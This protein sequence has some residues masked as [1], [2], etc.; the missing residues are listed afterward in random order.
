MWPAM[1]HRESALHRS[2]IR[3]PP[4]TPRGGPRGPAPWWSCCVEL[5]YQ[6]NFTPN[7]TMV[8]PMIEMGSSNALPLFQV[9]FWAAAEF[10]RL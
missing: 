3:R 5:A 7:R 6:S 1:S 9:M 10:V 8:G 2:P 4:Y